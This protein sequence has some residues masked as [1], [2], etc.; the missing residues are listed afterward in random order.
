MVDTLMVMLTR[1]LRVPW[2]RAF[3]VGSLVCVGIGA[4]LLAITVSGIKWPGLAATVSRLPDTSHG[5]VSVPT[6][7]DSSIPVI[8]QN[9]P[10]ITP[11]PTAHPTRTASPTNAGATPTPGYSPSLTMPGM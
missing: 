7:V 2:L 5:P 6:P 1:W 9:P 3:I 4:L 11:T 10:A 8:L